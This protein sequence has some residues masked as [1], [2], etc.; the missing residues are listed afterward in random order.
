MLAVGKGGKSALPGVDGGD[1]ILYP[2]VTV[3]GEDVELT[4]VNH[5]ADAVVALILSIQ[6]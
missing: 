5:G 4:V 3:S 6:V 1:A 2:G